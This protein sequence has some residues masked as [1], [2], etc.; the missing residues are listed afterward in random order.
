[1]SNTGGGLHCLT[2]SRQNVNFRTRPRPSHA[3]SNLHSRQQQLAQNGFHAARLHL[4]VAKA[5]NFVRRTLVVNTC[6][7]H[8]TPTP[9][10]V[11]GASQSAAR[12]RCAPVIS[13][14]QRVIMCGTHT[15]ETHEARKL[16]LHCTCAQARCSFLLPARCTR[17]VLL[18]EIFNENREMLSAL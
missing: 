18:A 1:V 12:I 7:W 2:L 6:M 8:D 17:V 13:A 11:V 15:L 10:S 9:T 3:N 5:L 4:F 14:F 16:H